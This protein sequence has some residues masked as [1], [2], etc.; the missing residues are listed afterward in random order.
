MPATLA[1]SELRTELTM[2][3]DALPQPALVLDTDRRVLAVNRQ[4]KDVFGAAETENRPPC[5]RLLHGQTQVCNLSGET[6]PLDLC[7]QTGEA[8]RSLHLHST[9]NGAQH[10]D[11]TI[12]PITDSQGRID[13]FLQILTPVDLARAEPSDTG[14]V[15]RSTAFTRMLEQINRVAEIPSPVLVSGEP[16]TGKEVVARAIHDASRRASQ[17]FVPVDCSSL[18]ETLFEREAFGHVSGAYPGANHNAV[19][20]IGAA[21]GGTLF[22]DEVSELPAT[23]QARI[24][25]LIES[26]SFRPEGSAEMIQADFRVVSSSDKNLEALARKGAFRG[27]LLLAISTLRIQIPPLK[28]RTEDIPLLAESLLERLGCARKGRSLHPTTVLVLKVYDFPGNVR[29]LHSILERACLLADGR[30]ILPRHLP[31][32]CLRAYEQ[33]QAG[34]DDDEP[35]NPS[36]VPGCP[37]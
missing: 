8:A 23:L 36:S 16:G 26:G 25:R 4:F 33:Q 2:M 15:G 13:S 22:L 29:E 18:R 7:W 1:K 32:E 9:S 20:L 34:L 3:L 19:G 5:Y 17:P 35:R 12:R 28:D 27:D 21:E 37:L 31:P 14:L 11:V 6:C 30:E 10:V 24:L